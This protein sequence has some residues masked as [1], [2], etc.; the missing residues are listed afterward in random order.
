MEQT[1]CILANVRSIFW[2]LILAFIPID[3]PPSIAKRVTY[4]YMIKNSI[5]QRNTVFDNRSPKGAEH[6]ISTIRTL[7]GRSIGPLLLSYMQFQY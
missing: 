2:A 7:E 1:V 5:S 3:V 6:Y 4:H